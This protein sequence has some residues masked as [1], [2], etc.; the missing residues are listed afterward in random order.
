MTALSY[1]Q[2]L[3]LHPDWSDAEIIAYCKGYNGAVSEVNQGNQNEERVSAEQ[4][5]AT[6]WKAEVK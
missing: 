2:V 6:N 1:E 4:I 5:Q 3:E